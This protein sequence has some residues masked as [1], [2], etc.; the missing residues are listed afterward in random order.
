MKQSNSRNT[1]RDKV[2][3]LYERLS[4]EDDD[5][6]GDS[7]SI[8]NQQ[9]LLAKAATQKGYT[10]LVHFY[11]DGITGVTMDRP[12]FN[13]MMEELKL[14]K[15]G[16]V[17]VK[18][19]SRL[20]RNYVEV[21]RLMEYFFPEHDIRL[22]AVS[23]NV[24]TF[25]GEDELVPIKNVFNEWYARDISRKRRASNRVKGTAG[26][27]LSPP[28]YGYI[29]DP[30]NPDF[31]I[32]DEE[33]AKVVR[34]I[35]T[36]ALSGYGTEQIATMLSEEKILTPA[37]YAVSKGI[38]KP[39]RGQKTDPYL[40][41]SSTI[42]K[43]LGL[44]EYC[45]DVINFKTHSKSFKNKKRIKND[46][47]DILVFQDVHEPIRDRDTFAMLQKMRGKVRKRKTADGERNMFSGLLVCAD[48][49]RNLHFHFNQRNPAIQYFNCPGY[50]MGKRKCCDSTHYIRVDFLEQVVLGEI[51]RLTRFACKY[52]TEFTQ[53]VA[54]FSRE[55]VER[56][57]RILQGELK[58]LMERNKELDT[59]FEHIYEDNVSGKIS[60]ERF[61][62]LSSKYEAEQ[63]EIVGRVDQ[64]QKSLD[65]MKE[66][67]DNT[68]HF[69][70][71]VRKYTRAKKLTPLM[72]NELIDHIEVHQAEKHSGITRQKLVIHY[73]CVGA[74]D[75]P[76]I[77]PLDAPKVVMQTRKG[78]LVG[79][80]PASIAS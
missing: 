55:V 9:K 54:N 66:K 33:A 23:D 70:A 65:A 38:R 46:P 73:N 63:H 14:G 12:E 58:A 68:E 2:A 45:G 10:K 61:V 42:S 64:L 28:P 22:V 11:D 44:Q 26:I 1:R 37:A 7:Y 78:V 18:D 41:R 57:Q 20:G 17:F 8:T 39:N 19:L 48:C 32:V 75:I 74:F 51:R 16:A 4:R 31:W 25:E 59:L 80:E 69:I 5:V 56:D 27:P 34:H 13:R 77:L 43:I 60:D 53:A 76:D 71:S 15:A 30:A 52:E 3:F 79:Y 21:G 49:G 62:K 6:E 72:L 35:D 50:N 40:W 36:L 47:E 24:D 29:K 67:V